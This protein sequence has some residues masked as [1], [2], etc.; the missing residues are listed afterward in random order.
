[1]SYL[2]VIQHLRKAEEKPQKFSLWKN[3]TGICKTGNVILAHA[4]KPYRES[5]SVAPVILNL[6]IRSR[7][8]IILP[9][10]IVFPQGKSTTTVFNI[11]L[12]AL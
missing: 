7:Q 2:L 5:K 9:P 3:D 4:K 11:S 10:P 8:V 12:D 6:T 1:M